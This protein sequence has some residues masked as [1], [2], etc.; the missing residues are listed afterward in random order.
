MVGK[1]GEHMAKAKYLE[2]ITEKGLTLIRGWA[3]DGL[4]DEQIAHNMGISPSTYYKWQ[5]EHSEI[6]EALKKGKEVVDFEVENALLKKAMGYNATVKKTFKV[7]ITE[8]DPVTG[9]KTKEHEELKSAFDE[10]HV[11]ADTVAQIFWLKNRCR[12]KWQDRPVP[13]DGK[14]V[15]DEWISAVTEESDT[16]E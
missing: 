9:R 12:D 8:F 16:D 7:K 11:P 15:V 3:R 1:V 6:S 13:V 2:W 10:I 5:N 4:T 14:D